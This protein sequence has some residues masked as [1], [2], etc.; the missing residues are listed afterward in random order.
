VEHPPLMHV[1]ETEEPDREMATHA[2]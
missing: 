1:G 2:R